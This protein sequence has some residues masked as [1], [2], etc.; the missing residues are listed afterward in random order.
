MILRVDTNTMTS[1]LDEISDCTRFHIEVTGSK[2]AAD[3]DEAIQG[4]GRV[5]GE[6]AWIALDQIEAMAAGKVGD[7]W[8]GEF[9]AMVDAMGRQGRL[10]DERDYLLAPI[11]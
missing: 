6:N 5:F 3:V 8:A 4:K 11:D 2:R 1:E 10:N 9:R 7:S